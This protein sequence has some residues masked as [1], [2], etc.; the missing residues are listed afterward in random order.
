LEE[1][2]A[3][4]KLTACV[5]R[6]GSMWT[7]FFGVAQVANADDARQCDRDFFRRWFHGMLEEGFYLPPSPFEAAF[8]S[9]AHT[10]AEIDA[11]VAAAKRVLRRLSSG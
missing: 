11:T 8:L 6:V 3:E 1:A 5:N 10:E 4:A 2:I 9:L 7:V